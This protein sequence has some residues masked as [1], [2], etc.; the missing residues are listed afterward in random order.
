[1]AIPDLIV[2]FVRPSG[3]LIQSMSHTDCLFTGYQST[4]Y[5][6]LALGL[7]AHVKSKLPSLLLT[8]FVS[9]SFKYNEENYM[10]KRSSVIF[11]DSLLTIFA[12]RQSKPTQMSL[13]AMLCVKRFVQSPLKAS[14]LKH[15]CIIQLKSHHDC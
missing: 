5:P 2:M 14:F 11:M 8:R 6:P 7:G 4:T 15:F 9:T 10:L 13:C 1:M 12:H 3:I